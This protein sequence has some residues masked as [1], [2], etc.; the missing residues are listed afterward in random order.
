MLQFC[1]VLRLTVNSIILPQKTDCKAK[2]NGLPRVFDP[3]NDIV[4]ETFRSQVAAERIENPVIA[5]P[6]GLWRSVPSSGDK[7]T[8]PYLTVYACR[9]SINSN[10]P[11]KVNAPNISLLF[12]QIAS[13]PL[14]LPICSSAGHFANVKSNATNTLSKANNASNAVPIG[15][16]TPF[17]YMHGQNKNTEINEPTIQYISNSN[18]LRYN[19][20]VRI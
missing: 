9:L 7:R 6:G 10:V 13:L 19:L 12:P 15:R 20:G 14:Q 5:K 2:K 17:R 18:G 16:L 1:A 8:V 11:C 3:R 4:F